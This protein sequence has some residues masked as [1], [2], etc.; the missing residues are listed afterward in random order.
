MVGPEL[1]SPGTWGFHV[2]YGMKPGRMN[3]SGWSDLI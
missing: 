2:E 1:R 3:Q